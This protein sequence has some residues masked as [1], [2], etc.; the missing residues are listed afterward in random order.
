MSIE[1]VRAEKFGGINGTDE[2]TFCRSMP[3]LWRI[4]VLFIGGSGM[5]TMSRIHGTLCGADEEN[6]GIISN[7]AITMPCATREAQQLAARRSM[8]SF[9]S[10]IRG[11]VKRRVACKAFTPGAALDNEEA[12]LNKHTAWADFS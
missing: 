11:C 5:T 3:R 9:S 7:A 8:G 1:M 10:T 12:K 2:S 6:S 4:T